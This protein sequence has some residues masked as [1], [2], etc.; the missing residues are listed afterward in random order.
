MR[1]E[2]REG[3]VRS[4][5]EFSQVFQDLLRHFFFSFYYIRFWIYY[6]VS[7]VC[8]FCVDH[9]YLEFVFATLA[10]ASRVMTWQ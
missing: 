7:V 6:T 2:Q 3:G 1:R 8:W 4:V 5:R 10:W 9:L